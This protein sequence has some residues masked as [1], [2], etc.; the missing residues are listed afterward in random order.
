M[1]NRAQILVAVIFG[2]LL[3][4]IVLGQGDLAWMALP[5]L[6]YLAWGILKAP[7]TG[8]I[9]LLATRSV[10]AIHKGGKT[11]VNV[12]TTVSNHGVELEYLSLFDEPQFGVQLVDG[13]FRQS[14]VLGPDETVQLNYTFQTERGSFSWDTIQAIASDPLGLID[15]Q[16]ALPA[17][18]T[19]QAPPEVRKIRPFPLRTQ[20]TLPSAGSIPARR[21]GSGTDFWGIREYHPGDP[22]QRLNWRLIARHPRHFFTKEFEQEALA[23]IGLVLDARG[24]TN[25]QRDDDSLFEH[26]ARATASLAEMFLRQGNR[27]SLLIWG[28]PVVS[29]FPGYGKGQLNRILNSLAQV[30]PN[31][32]NS[33]NELHFVP[34]QM[35]SSQSLILVISPLASNDWRLFPRLRAFGYQVL[36]ISPDPLNYVRSR[37]STDQN[38]RLASRLTRLER[39]LE[40]AKIRRLWVPVIDWSVSQP[41]SPLVRQ[42]LTQ[43]HIQITQ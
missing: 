8:N 36:L 15:V 40:I 19:L 21:G 3:G 14:S 7:T 26:S 34:T 39:Q 38:G 9:Q 43:T 35:F 28:E 17:A 10:E 13:Q 4:A 11:L 22:L 31:S 18:A 2:L 42:A 24:K 32:D 1:N 20:R 29:V 27:V 6:V 33:L 5:F 23:D 37:L 25:V 16:R 12:S 30:T 41:L